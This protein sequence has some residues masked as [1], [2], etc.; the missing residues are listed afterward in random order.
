M[1][2]TK[3]TYLFFN[4]DT[5]TYLH[6]ATR[7]LTSI[8]LI[9]C[10]PSLFMDFTWRK[11]FMAVT[12]F[13]SFRKAIN[14]LPHDRPPE[15][16]FHNADWNLF[17]KICFQWPTFRIFLKMGVSNW[18]LSLTSHRSHGFLMSARRIFWTTRD[19]LELSKL[20]IPTNGNLQE[21]L[22]KRAKERQVVRINKKNNCHE[23]ASKLNARTSMKKCWD[24]V[25][26]IKGTGEGS[27]YNHTVEN[28]QKI[29]ESRD[30]AKTIWEAIS[31][32]THLPH[33]TKL[34]CSASKHDQKDI[35]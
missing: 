28:R 35:H 26:K 19:L 6:S 32:N 16:M 29:K 9:M 18:R 10:S 23:Y 1:F 22:I 15:W 7:S 21:Y 12:K 11:F 34:K 33:I 30:I 4:D 8:D 13:L 27:I 17:S 14:H 5:P 31:H 3:T 24:M 20:L 25:C 2:M